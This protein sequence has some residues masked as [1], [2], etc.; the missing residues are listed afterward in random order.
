M[1]PAAENVWWFNLIFSS[2]TPSHQEGEMSNEI[3]ERTIK[4]RYIVKVQNGR[5][6]V[7]KREGKAMRC[8]LHKP[9]LA[10]YLFSCSLLA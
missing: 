10:T 6:N 7:G 4:S 8:R 2:L 1:P 3:S 9:D 5:L